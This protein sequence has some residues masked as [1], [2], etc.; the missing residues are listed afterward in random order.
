MRSDPR[1]V[2]VTGAAGFIGRNL[3]VRLEEQGCD[4]RRIT[5]ASTRQEVQAALG[6]ADVVFHLAAAIRPP[7][8]MEFLHTVA[9]A[10][11]VAAAIARGGRKPLVV[12]S[13]SRRASEDTGFGASTR[14]CE[15]AVLRLG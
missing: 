13:S 4:V 15:E 14:A 10:N 7:D 1:I 11:D 6:A 12:L 2:A 8:P 5:H 9:F 3:V